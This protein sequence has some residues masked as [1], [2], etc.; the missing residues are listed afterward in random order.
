MDNRS[1]VVLVSADPEWDAVRKRFPDAVFDKSP[2]GEYFS[3]DIPVSGGFENI[4]F[5]HGGWGKVAG[6]GSTQY[7]ISR[8]S[9]DYLIV[10][11]TCGGFEGEVEV[12]DIILAERTVIYDIYDEMLDEDWSLSM[13]AVDLDLDWLPETLPIPVR[14]DLFVSADRDLN[15]QHIPELKKKYSAVAGDW[16]TGAIAFVAARNQV[17]CLIL[18]GVSDL[19]SSQGGEAYDN[20]E[21]YIERAGLIMNKLIDSL[22]EWVEIC[23]NAK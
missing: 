16:E 6:A 5:L 11:G 13:F 21:L 1:I 15:P 22:P 19:V 3:T 20:F 18:K 8:W 12:G 10:L 14:R 9:P 2:Y 17:H 23:L 7:L 4:L